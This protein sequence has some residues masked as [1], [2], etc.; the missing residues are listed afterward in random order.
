MP[1]FST[2][3]IPAP[4]LAAARDLY[5]KLL[6]AEPEMDAPYYVQFTFDGQVIGLDPRGTQVVAHLHVA[7]IDAAVSLVGAAGG[8]VVT[9]TQDVGG[10]KRVAVMEDPAGATIGLVQL[11]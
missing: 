11:A 2:I 9:P 3:L 7:D 6:S 8:K 1:N 10:G 4:D 5:R